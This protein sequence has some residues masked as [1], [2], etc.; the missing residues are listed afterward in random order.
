MTGPALPEQYLELAPRIELIAESHERLLGKPLVEGEEPVAALW[1]AE[2]AILA[3]GVEADPIFFFGNRTAL[4]LF[5]ANTEQF[6]SLPSRK[7]AEAPLRAEREELMR[8]VRES[9]YI[10]DYS[11]VR[12]SLAG[13]RFRIERATVW[14]LVDGAGK[15]HGQAAT[16]NEWTPL[17]RN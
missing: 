11:G 9:G 14:N 12:I 4:R 6:M 1:E 17:E 7:S 16:F 3:H 8:R 2:P 13:D 5:D 15:I 10:D